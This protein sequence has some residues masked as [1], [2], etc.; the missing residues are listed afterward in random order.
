MRA[1]PNMKPD[2]LSVIEKYIQDRAEYGKAIRCPFHGEHDPSLHLY[3]DQHWYCFGCGKSGDVYDFVGY[4]RYG[5]SWDCKNTE[6]FISV[7]KELES[8]SCKTVLYDRFVEKQDKT[9]S[10]E[11]AEYLRWACSVYHKTLLYS[12]TKEAENARKYLTARGYS[13]SVIKRLKIGYAGK[14]VLMSKSCTFSKEQ[15]KD[16]IEKFKALGLIKEN[17][18]G[19][20]EYYRD[21]I[22][23]PNVTPEGNVINL[24]GRAVWNSN[25]RYLNIPDIKK[26]LYLIQ[27]MNPAFPVFLTESVTDTVSMWQL[28]FQTVATNGTAL[29]KRMVS[30]L[31][32]FKE[33][34]IV[35]QNDMPSVNAA[36][37]WASLIPRA[38]IVYPEYI[39][40]QQ[41]DIND[42]L[43]QEGENR[44]R[45]KINI[46][47]RHPMDVVEYTRLVTE[48]Y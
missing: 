3:D 23:F 6:M 33:I 42:I 26:D 17:E 22:M 29:S 18:R 27:M 20:Y 41:K 14:N 5:D 48:K 30:S 24:T 2:L 25:K 1:Q 34:R 31:E 11:S 28:G 35:P 36:N 19:V 4:I 15:R 46:A 45:A 8:S 40:G 21:R 47:A 13:E 37:K 39:D 12:K 43:Q 9:L 16:Y 38:K 10:P 44:A 7:V 32:P